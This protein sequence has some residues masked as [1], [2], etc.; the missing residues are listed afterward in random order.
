MIVCGLEVGSKIVYTVE[1]TDDGV[2]S[3]MDESMSWLAGPRV[4]DLQSKEE[5]EFYRTLMNLVY[6]RV[7]D[8]IKRKLTE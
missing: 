2:W 4:L 6:N 3:V 5:A 8:D 7:M 1:E